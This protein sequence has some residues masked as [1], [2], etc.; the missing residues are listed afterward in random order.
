MQNNVCQEK[1]KHLTGTISIMY[2]HTIWSAESKLFSHK[3]IMSLMHRF[4]R[5]QC[6]HQIRNMYMAVI[7]ACSVD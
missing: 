1:Q 7:L 3:P 6:L 2:V 4:P 5:G